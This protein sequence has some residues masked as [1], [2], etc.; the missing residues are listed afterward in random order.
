MLK[1]LSHHLTN[2]WWMV[3]GGWWMVDGGWWM[4]DGGW[5]MVSISITNCHHDS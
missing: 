1:N 4:V 5:W 2:T 3:D